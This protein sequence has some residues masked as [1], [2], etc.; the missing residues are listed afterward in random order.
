ML[1]WERICPALNCANAQIRA[2][3]DDTAIM[4]RRSLIRP[5]AVLFMGH[6]VHPNSNRGLTVI[7]APPVLPTNQ[8]GAS[9]TRQK[10]VA[11]THYTPMIS[12][13]RLLIPSRKRTAILINLASA[14]REPHSNPRQEPRSRAASQID[15]CKLSTV[16]HQSTS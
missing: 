9:E 7:A 3:A 14:S 10:H 16:E 1:R 12:R 8:V 5:V 6:Y 13:W 4:F 2:E 15:N 11:M